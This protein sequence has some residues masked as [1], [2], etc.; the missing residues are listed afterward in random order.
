MDI[1]SFIY[2]SQFRT[3]PV[4]SDNITSIYQTPTVQY[5]QSN[6]I[7]L[8]YI[9]DEKPP[10]NLV[11][12]FMRYNLDNIISDEQKMFEMKKTNKTIQKSP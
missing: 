3:T 9:I 5:E 8:Q 1:N 2:P 11:R 4:I 10:T 12:E 6:V 7:T